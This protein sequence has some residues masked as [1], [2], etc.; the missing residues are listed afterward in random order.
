MAGRNELDYLRSKAEDSIREAVRTSADPW[1]NVA[2]AD[3]IMYHA[4]VLRSMSPLSDQQVIMDVP[5]TDTNPSPGRYFPTASRTGFR[6][7]PYGRNNWRITSDVRYRNHRGPCSYLEI[8]QPHRHLRRDSSES[9]QTCSVC[10]E[11]K[12]YRT[13]A[14]YSDGPYNNAATPDKADKSSE[15]FDPAKRP[16]RPPVEKAEEQDA[17][18]NVEMPPPE[19][20]SSPTDMRRRCT[21]EE[22]VRV[23]WSDG[24]CGTCYRDR[25]ESLAALTQEEYKA[26]SQEPAPT[27]EPVSILDTLT[28]ELEVMEGKLTD[29]QTFVDAFRGVVAF[30]KG[31]SNDD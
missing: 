1:G 8:A 10:G 14:D 19:V 29:L 16:G 4:E 15:A 9:V 18:G 22:C 25:Y 11:S 20:K 3:A 13:G 12:P 26:R 24:L 31:R 6:P 30:Y 23:S 17:A 28:S 2:I 5:Q 27:P 7:V 21:T